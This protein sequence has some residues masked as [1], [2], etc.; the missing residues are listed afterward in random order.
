MEK[1]VKGAGAAGGENGEADPAKPKKVELVTFIESKRGQNMGIAIS[2]FKTLEGFKAIGW[3]HVQN[4]LGAMDMDSL[5]GQDG[6]DMLATCVPLP[7]TPRHL[8]SPPPFV[9]HL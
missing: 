4:A 8:S 6:I 3:K 5:L 2:K 7:R 9:A 1:A